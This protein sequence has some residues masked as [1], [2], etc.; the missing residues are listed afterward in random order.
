MDWNVEEMT[1]MNEK[2]NEV[3]RVGKIYSC[4]NIDR[5]EK[6]DFI[7]KLYDGKMSYIVNLIDKFEYDKNS[8]PKGTY[9][10]VKTVSLKAW[11]KR[12]DSLEIVD[13]DYKYGRIRFLDAQR[14]ITDANVKG[15]YDTH[16]NIVDEYFHRTLKN[17]EREEQKYFK[18]HDEYSIL[19]DK[20]TTKNYGTTFGVQIS[21]WSAGEICIYDDNN[22]QREITIDELKLLLSKYEELDRL[23]EKITG[24]VNIKY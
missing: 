12:N 5:Q 11:L 23:I 8:L 1:L 10:Y 24:E 6:I 19:K 17:C 3:Q 7:D 16:K 9:E 4:E 13:R 22:N 2:D 14:Y 21:S 15:G 20:F 18:K